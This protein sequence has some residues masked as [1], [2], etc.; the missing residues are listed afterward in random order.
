MRD[1][2]ATIGGFAVL[3]L[4]WGT[5]FLVIREGLRTM[6][7]LLSVSLRFAVLAIA[8]AIAARVTGAVAS[9]GSFRARLAFGL[10]QAISFGL[11]YVA[12]KRIDAGIAG[13]LSSTTPLFVALLA[14][15]FIREE[16]LRPTTALALL[17]GFGGASLL[18]LGAKRWA[19]P[20][21]S[22]A[23]TLVLLGELAGAANKVLGKGLLVR[24]P[25]LV[26]LRDMGLIVAVATAGGWLLFERDERVELT[27]RG[28]L[29]FAYLGLVA[30]FGG[31][32]L[33]MRLLRVLPVTT[34][35]YLQFATALV[36]S[37][38]GVV[39]GH[40]HPAPGLIP[41][42]AAILA[43]LAVLGWNATRVSE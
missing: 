20:A 31:S 16:R 15:L 35:G 26:L 32:S 27:P 24:I 3:G 9:R 18:V 10:M 7:A 29:A 14:H 39:I 37:A 42:A 22:L 17:L 21:V 1:A 41:A 4:V 25:P 38:A 12:Q 34:L 43:G 36:A 19:A 5:Q 8:A 11:L 40:E 33:Y 13:L 30:S 2:I 28:V 23:M 6:P